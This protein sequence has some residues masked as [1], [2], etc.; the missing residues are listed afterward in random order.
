MVVV[1]QTKGGLLV[2]ADK[3]RV[4]NNPIHGDTFVDDVV[5][6]FEID[7]NAG[8]FSM[9]ATSFCIAEPAKPCLMPIKLHVSSGRVERRRM[10]RRFP[11]SSV[12]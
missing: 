5:K 1:M 12:I 10:P 3:R 11:T 9:G 2:C 7:P 4:E 6:I 8:F